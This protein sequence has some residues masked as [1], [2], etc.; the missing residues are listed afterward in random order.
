MSTKYRFFRITY[1]GTPHHMDFTLVPI[2]HDQYVNNTDITYVTPNGNRTS[3]IDVDMTP[4][5]ATGSPVDVWSKACKKW[6]KK[7]RKKRI[8]KYI[9]KL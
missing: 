5:Y 4:S 7:E 8:E 1:R 6:V 2:T 3:V 9:T